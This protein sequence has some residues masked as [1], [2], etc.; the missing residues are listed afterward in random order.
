MVSLAVGKSGIVLWSVSVPPDEWMVHDIKVHIHFDTWQ[1][2]NRWL[3]C[4]WLLSCFSHISKLH[5]FFIKRKTK[6]YEMNPFGSVRDGLITVFQCVSC[7]TL[8]KRM[9]KTLSTRSTPKWIIVTGHY[10]RI[11]ES[12]DQMRRLGHFSSI[13]E[14][15]V[16]WI[17]LFA[18]KE[19]A[20]LNISNEIIVSDCIHFHFFF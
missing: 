11:S 16:W 12:R 7:S 17:L 14:V 15:F 9:T 19:L 18:S 3:S 1:R 6:W 13:I 20:Q 10:M 2:W 4:C 8:L 5:Y